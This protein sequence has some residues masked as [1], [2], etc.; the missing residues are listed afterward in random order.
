MTIKKGNEKPSLGLYNSVAGVKVTLLLIEMNGSTNIETAVRIRP[1][2]S[3]E[4]QENIKPLWQVKENAIV[5]IADE[6]V[7]G[8]SYT[9]GKSLKYM[10]MSG[11]SILLRAF[12]L[13]RSYI[14]GDENKS[15]CV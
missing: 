10:F 6:T 1:Y 9:F 15:R 11:C 7:I 13:F 3:C 14:R 2:I 8:E 4:K 12:M 5:Q